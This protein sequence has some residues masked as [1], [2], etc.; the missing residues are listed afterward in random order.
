MPRN[1]HT[2]SLCGFGLPFLLKLRQNNS[3][4]P[5]ILS[6]SFYFQSVISYVATFA[7]FPRNFGTIIVKNLL[8]ICEIIPADSRVIAL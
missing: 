6:L 1:L 7:A 2:C 8:V 3:L 4:V 5:S